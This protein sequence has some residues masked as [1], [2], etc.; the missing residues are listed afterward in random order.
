MPCLPS[1]A[2]PPLGYAVATPPPPLP[3]HHTGCTAGPAYGP[4]GQATAFH[5]AFT[6][7]GAGWA[8]RWVAG[9]EA[10]KAAAILAAAGSTALPLGQQQQPALSKKA[11]VWSHLGRTNTGTLMV[12]RQRAGLL[13]LRVVLN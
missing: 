5:P 7:Q 2:P 13:I 11:F 9:F 8:A 12:C 3:P 1:R 6:D 4:T 10:D